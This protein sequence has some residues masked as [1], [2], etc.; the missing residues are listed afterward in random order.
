MQEG[1]R[2]KGW[3]GQWSQRAPGPCSGEVGGEGAPFPLV[4]AAGCAST[5]TTST[6]AAAA[7]A[8][9]GRASSA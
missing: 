7:A 6:A 2:K 5:T 4:G 9:S 8:A 3:F 1:C